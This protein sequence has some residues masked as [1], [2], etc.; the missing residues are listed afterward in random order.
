MSPLLSF[1]LLISLCFARMP[2]VLFPGYW[3]HMRP[4]WVDLEAPMSPVFPRYVAS[5][6]GW[7]E[8]PRV[9]TSCPCPWPSGIVVCYSVS[10]SPG[11]VLEYI[12]D[13]PAPSVLF[14]LVTWSLVGLD[15]YLFLSC[16]LPQWTKLSHPKHL[17]VSLRENPL[18]FG[19]E[20]HSRVLFWKRLGETQMSTDVWTYQ[21]VQ[22]L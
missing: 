22:S 6:R 3:A 14:V 20:E 2:G 1:S 7:Q 19:L 5:L 4:S 11:A 17:P 8:R 18:Y 16:F 10:T 12:T 9:S 13:W 15:L 21:G